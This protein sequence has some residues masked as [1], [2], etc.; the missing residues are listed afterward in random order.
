MAID[1]SA[2]ATIRLRAPAKIN[3][4]LH[5]TGRRTDGFHELES[6]VAFAGI[7]DGVGFRPDGPAGLE[8]TGPEAGALDGLEPEDNLVMQA[9]RRLAGALGK[10]LEGTLLLDKQLPSAAGLGGGSADAAAVLQLLCDHWR[11]ERDDVDLPGIGL[12]LGADVP[13]CLQSGS[14][15]VAGMGENL[16]PSG[17]L[18]AAHLVLINPREALSTAAVFSELGGFGKAEAPLTGD[19]ADVRSLA[20]ELGRRHNDLETPAKTLAP[21]IGDVISAL[22]ASDGCLMARMSGSGAS[23]FGLY[24]GEAE[25]AAAAGSISTESPDWWVRAAPLLTDVSSW[26]TL[27]A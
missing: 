12:S 25:A 24:A 9:A 18:P 17:S 27:R 5:V 14:S 1:G 11:V 26:K 20:A 21:V 22:A 8:I 7:G 19:V 13:V 16:R 23:C 6:L 3:L 4:Y 10:P 2:A 15:L